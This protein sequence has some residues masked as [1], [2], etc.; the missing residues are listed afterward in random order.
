MLKTHL[1]N[2]SGALVRNLSLS[3][4]I[5]PNVGLSSGG[6]ESCF[7][8][9]PILLVYGLDFSFVKSR[10]GISVNPSW[11]AFVELY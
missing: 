10:V 2:V 8:R 5:G 9:G 4:K 1:T 7:Y 6:L 11:F 3:S